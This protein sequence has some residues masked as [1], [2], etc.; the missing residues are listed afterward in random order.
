MERLHYLNER[1]NHGREATLREIAERMISRDRF[2]LF[3]AEPPA[4]VTDLG[5]SESSWYDNPVKHKEFRETRTF[6]YY[7]QVSED[8]T[9]QS[10]IRY[11]AKSITEI[12]AC[13]FTHRRDLMWTTSHTDSYPVVMT[14]LPPPLRWF[15]RFFDK[16]FFDEEF[17]QMAKDDLQVRREKKAQRQ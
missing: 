12:T 4:W 14:M 2:D 5:V 3:F 8:G 9:L 7:K 13:N 6:G 15:K 1:A 11:G 10:I 17:V 16:A